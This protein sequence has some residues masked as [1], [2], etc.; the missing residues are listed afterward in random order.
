MGRRLQSAYSSLYLGTAVEKR[1]DTI[2]NY[3][4]EELQYQETSII[5][6]SIL[7]YRRM[8][9]FS[10]SN[11]C[12]Y[13]IKAYRGSRRITPLILNHICTALSFY[14]LLLTYSEESE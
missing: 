11:C 2:K 9:Y 5:E 7:E 14:V 6:N 3:R 4:S 13:A 8:S 12:V 10:M 1:R